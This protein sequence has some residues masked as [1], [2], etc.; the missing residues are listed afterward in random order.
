MLNATPIVTKRLILRRWQESDLEPFA[1]LNADPR[2]MQYFPSLLSAEESNQMAKRMDN[3]IVERG[4][5]WWAASLQSSADFIGF[6]GL[7]EV[8]KQTLPAPFTPA[9]EIGWRL[10]Y[11]FWGKGYATEGALQALKYGFSVLNLEEIVS[12][13]ALPNQK[14][15]QVMQR[16]G[17][18]RD[19]K[20]DFDHPKLPEGHALRRHALY[21]LKK[22]EW[23]DI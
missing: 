6:I 14:S 15:M 3:K 1:K 2:V 17:M 10:A 16:I 8:D 22:R 23:H 9:V 19:V 12:F 13:T 4:W 21:R 11:D 5:G 7:N 20:D 18:H